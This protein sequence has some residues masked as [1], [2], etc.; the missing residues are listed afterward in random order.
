M[1][2]AFSACNRLFFCQVNIL[3][4]R[5]LEQ[6]PRFYSY[7]CFQKSSDR[8]IACSEYYIAPLPRGLVFPKSDQLYQ[9]GFTYKLTDLTKFTKLGCFTT[10]H[11]TL[12][13]L[14]N[15]A[16]KRKAP[17]YQPLFEHHNH[18]ITLNLQLSYHSTLHV[19]CVRTLNI[20]KCQ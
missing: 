8:P 4:R 14:C 17:G 18:S 11:Y 15:L 16:G 6:A 5:V 9:S 13:H 10:H 1:T 2:S 12:H 7:H 3:P 19:T 20:Y